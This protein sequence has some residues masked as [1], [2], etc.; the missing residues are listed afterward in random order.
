MQT[1]T[2][3]ND[4]RQF[5]KCLS[6]YATGIAVVTCHDNNGLPHGRTI[7]SFSSVSLE[8]PLVL[9]SLSKKAHSLNAFLEARFFA[10]NV[11]STRQRNL[12]EHFASSN[13]KNFNNIDYMLSNNNAPILVDNLATFHCKAHD[14]YSCGDHFIIIGEVTC[15]ASAKQDPLIF[16]NSK[17]TKVDE[18]AGKM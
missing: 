8:P 5:R 13:D 4:T 10:I 1:P 6:K 16:F 3:S 15:F 17:Y 2:Y 7:N 12:S 14:I 18:C 9:W 11:L